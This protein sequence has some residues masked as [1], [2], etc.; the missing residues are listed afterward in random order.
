MASISTNNKY[1]YILYGTYTRNSE[2][3]SKVLSEKLETLGF[4]IKLSSLDDSI[5]FDFK[6]SLFV[7]IICST[8]R[9]GPPETAE[10]WWRNIKK[11]DI[12]KQKFKDIKY[13]VLG[14]G[15]TNY[16][17]FCNM[18]IEIDKR[19]TELSGNRIHKLVCTDAATDEVETIETWIDN[20]VALVKDY[21]HSDNKSEQKE[22][23]KYLKYKNKYLKLKQ[24]YL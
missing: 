17:K 21:K 16:P 9:G 22:K 11:K 4:K 7:F 8:I 19:I 24:F 12:D 23:N 10:K 20:I 1:I 14:L 6:D 15:D 2:G 13:A 18:G 5:D 3:V